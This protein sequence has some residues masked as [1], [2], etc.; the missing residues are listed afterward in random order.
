MEKSARARLPLQVASGLHADSWCEINVIGV[1][2]GFGPR[3]RLNEIEC[4]RGRSVARRPQSSA[5]HDPGVGAMAMQHRRTARRSIAVK[6]QCRQRCNAAWSYRVVSSVHS[7]Y[8]QVHMVLWY[9]IFQ[10]LRVHLESR[11][12]A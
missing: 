6:I 3:L 7:S 2:T 5:L 9:E 12:K 4:S 1:V 8:T 10:M 11:I